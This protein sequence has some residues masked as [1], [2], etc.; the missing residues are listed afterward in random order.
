[1]QT[2]RQFFNLIFRTISR[3]ATVALAITFLLALAV[4]LTQAAQAQTF[5]VIHNFTGGASGGNSFA[6]LTLDRAGNLYGT[7]CGWDCDGGVFRLSKKGSGWVLNPLYSF[8]GGNDGAYPSGKVIFG[9]DGSLYGSTG[10]GGGDGCGGYGCGTVF[11]VKPPAAACKTALC[12]WAETT[13][14]RFTE[15]PDGNYPSGDLVFDQAGNIYGVTNEGGSGGGCDGGC[16][17]VFKLTFSSGQWTE[18]ILYSFTGGSDGAYPDAGLIFDNLGNLYGTATAGGAYGNGVVFQLKP[19]GSGWTDNVLY[20]FQNGNDGRTPIGGLTFD[21]SGNLYGS[22]YYGGQG[23]SGTVFEL[24][25][26]GDSWIL[27]TLYSFSGP[28]W[29]GPADRLVMDAAGNLYGTTVVAPGDYGNGGVFE[30][31]PS[32]GAW[33]YTLLHAFNYNNDG[34]SPW[35]GVVLD[36]SGNLYGTT[37]TGGLFAEGTAWEITP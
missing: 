12:P 24:T 33:G 17:A 13:L 9:P 7:T 21:Q 10:A 29:G 14:Y 5:Q 8:V 3:M 27:S 6:A 20:S 28:G 1:M 26:S 15:S 2:K 35:G 23:G 31:T 16:G 34:A 30:L 36:G 18:S 11:N 37:C 25:P 4:M 22:T 32:S 19:S